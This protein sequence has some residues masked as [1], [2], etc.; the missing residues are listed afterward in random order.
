M[1]DSSIKEA[2]PKPETSVLNKL[3][4]VWIASDHAGFDLK[5][6][7]VKKLQSKP[8]LIVYDEGPISGERVDYPDYAWPLTLKLAQARQNNEPSFG[9]LICGTGIG[10]SLVAN[11][12]P[13]IRAALAHN[14]FTA[15]MARMHNDA[16]ILCLGAR[17]I[18]QDLAF[19]MVDCFLA[20]KF[21][22]GRHASRLQLMDDYREK[23]ES[24]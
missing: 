10:V 23:Y 3:T 14:I 6:L 16:Q 15:Q 2:L 9:I 11:Q 1:T 8:E 5:S 12:H 17:V 7:L 4:K 13:E 22:G 20:T 21:E 18:G 19:S 24:S